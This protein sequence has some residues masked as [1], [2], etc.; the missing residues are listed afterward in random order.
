MT[1]ERK[2]ILDMVA[3]GKISVEEAEQLL[4]AIRKSEEGQ[5]EEDK[6]DG[7]KN[8]K[9]M[10]V[11]VISKDK[12]NVDVKVPLKLLRSGIKL[13]SLIPPQA[14]DHINE[15]MEKQGLSFDLS[16]LNPKDLDELIQSLAELE[17]NVNSKDGDNVKVYC[18]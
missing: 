16:N 11:K 8:P 13:T 6:L 12:D 17:V 10:Y 4:D 14:M 3:S 9:F 1:E 18:A 5:T 2:R 7:K 15:S